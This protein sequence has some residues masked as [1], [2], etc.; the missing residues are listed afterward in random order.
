MKLKIFF[1]LCPLMLSAIA[2]GQSLHLHDI[3][4]LNHVSQA[5]TD[6]FLKSKNFGVCE[7]DQTGSVEGHQYSK[8]SPDCQK[9]F[10][11][12]VTDN[13]LSGHHIT[14]AFYDNSFY[15]QVLSELKKSGFVV[16]RK[17]E[18]VGCKVTD[19]KKDDQHMF[20]LRVCKQEEGNKYYLSIPVTTKK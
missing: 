3:V 10:N 11:E 5:S 19:Y 13:Y 4:A 14:Y 1:A 2:H 17:H 20:Q 8:Y 18:I 12:Y 16:K 9:E 7:T 15:K 6:S